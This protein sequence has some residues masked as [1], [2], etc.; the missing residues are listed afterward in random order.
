MNI[1]EVL[2]RYGFPDSVKNIFA[3][4]GLAEFFPPQAEAIRQGALDGENILMSVPTAAGKTLIAELCILR[5]LLENHGRALYIVPLKALASEKYEDFKKKY[6]QLEIKVGLATGDIETPTHYL[7]GYQLLVATAEKVDALLR[8]RSQWLMN[9]LNVVVIDEIHFLDDEE[10]GP[11]LEILIARIRQLN[12]KIQILALSATVSN[13]AEMARWLNAKLITSTWRPIPLHE[14][15]YY[16]RAITFQGQPTRLIKEDLED[17]LTNITLDTVKGKGQAIIFVNSRRSTQSVC[18]Q[19]SKE[20]GGTL[21][22]TERD[23]L[24]KLGQEIV[25]AP[26]EST[27]VCRKLGEMV[28]HGV[29]FHH[30]G[31][32]PSQR[33]LVEDHFRENLIKVICSTPTLAAGVNLPA[34]RAIIRDLKRFEL[35]LGASYIPVAEY[36]QCAGRAGRP[37]YDTSGE[38]V[39]MAKSSSESRTL[40]D[41]YINA[42]PEPINSKLGRE[43]A[44]RTHILASISGGYVHDINDTFAFLSQTFLAS[45]KKTTNFIE[46]ISEIFDFLLAEE[47]IEKRGF[48]FFATPFGQY[49]SRLYLDPLSAIILRKGLAKIEAGKSFSN[50]GLIHLIACCPDSPLLRFQKSEIEDI[51]LFFSNCQD[52]LIITKS[53]LSILDDYFYHLS[54]L[55]TTMMLTKWVEEEREEV[56]CD[57]FTIGPGDIYRHIESSRWLLHA[58]ITFAELLRFK[59]L[60]FLL[61]DLKTR[62]QYGVKEELV[63]LTRLKG[64]GRVRARHLFDNGIHQISDLKNLSADEIAS[65]EKI[66]KTLAESIIKQVRHETPTT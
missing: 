12:P 10:R 49:T 5:S 30:A 41:Q 32:K 26:G 64:I 31:L 40:F 18:R 61:S 59:K 36:K 56:L 38:A 1:P 29:A 39:L 52:E 63:S 9:G 8:T 13:A 58:A 50:M 45:Q 25:G 57:E 35:G 24:A 3:Q 14:G 28:C 46:L 33:K 62:I 53:D 16:Q 55:K 54:I 6:S 11:V 51:E 66:G 48:R 44:L 23:R 22:E 37:Q 20:V 43:S 34:R 65:I 42:T 17:D 47:F 19:I 27:K 21:T 4:A 7:S 2:T 60:T 15:V